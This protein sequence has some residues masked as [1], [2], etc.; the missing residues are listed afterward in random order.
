M[1]PCLTLLTYRLTAAFPRHTSVNPSKVCP[2]CHCLPIRCQSCP[3]TPQWPLYHAGP[4]KQQLFFAAD[5]AHDAIIRHGPVACLIVRSSHLNTSA[6]LTVLARKAARNSLRCPGLK[7]GPSNANVAPG[8]LQAGDVS[9]QTDV[10]FELWRRV[11]GDVFERWEQQ[12]CR[13]NPAKA[14]EPLKIETEDGAVVQ[15]LR[16]RLQVTLLCVCCCDAAVFWLLAW[17]YVDRYVRYFR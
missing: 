11:K 10:K 12:S 15:G 7:V 6:Q 13:L 8:L 4:A 9:N 5:L 14:P 17:R 2:A 1:L 16:H 3:Y